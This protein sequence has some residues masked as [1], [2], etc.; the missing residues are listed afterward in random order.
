M[1]PA[2]LLFSSSIKRNSRISF[3][4]AEQQRIRWWKDTWDKRLYIESIWIHKPAHTH[5]HKHSETQTD[6][7]N[8]LLP[9]NNKILFNTLRNYRNKYSEE[10]CAINELTFNMTKRTYTWR[11]K[12]SVEFASVYSRKIDLLSNALL[13]SKLLTF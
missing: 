8:T 6:N 3:S 2:L 12:L 11:T 7:I 13:R 10:D 9:L 5:T 4:L 1:F